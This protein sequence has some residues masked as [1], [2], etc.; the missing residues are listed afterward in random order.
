MRRALSALASCRGSL[1]GYSTVS[2]PKDYGIVMQKAAELAAEADVPKK[3]AGY[4]DG[5]PLETFKR[6]VRRSTIAAFL[7]CCA[8]ETLVGIRPR[9]TAA[10]C[11]QMVVARALVPA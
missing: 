3:E 4:A 2:G 7:S 11:R 9:N 6:K 8:T 5:V 1:A 10:G